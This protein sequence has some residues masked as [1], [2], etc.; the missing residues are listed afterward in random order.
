M[1]NKKNLSH[2]ELASK[3]LE[4]P[5]VKAEVERLAI[6]APALEDLLDQC[7]PDT[8]HGEI[9]FGKPVGKEIL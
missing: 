9:G 8:V 5:K 4:N 6:Y 1:M 2:E 3:M 7:D